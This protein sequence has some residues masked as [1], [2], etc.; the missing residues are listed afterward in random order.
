MGVAIDISN[1]R[2]GKLVAVERLSGGG[3]GEITMEELEKE[4]LN[5]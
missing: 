1:Q 4:K 5:G 2:F 3:P